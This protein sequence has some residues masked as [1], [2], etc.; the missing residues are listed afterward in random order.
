M[1]SSLSV[2]T[3]TIAIN[4]LMLDCCELH[5][6]LPSYSTRKGIWTIS[7]LSKRTCGKSFSATIR[8]EKIPSS[9]MNL[10]KNRFYLEKKTV[11]QCDLLVTSVQRLQQHSDQRHQQKMDFLL[12]QYLHTSHEQYDVLSTHSLQICIYTNGSARPQQFKHFDISGESDRVTSLFA[13]HVGPILKSDNTHVG[14]LKCHFWL[15]IQFDFLALNLYTL[16]NASVLHGFLRSTDNQCGKRL[17]SYTY[18]FRGKCLTVTPHKAKL[19]DGFL[20]NELIFILSIQS[21]DVPNL[22]AYASVGASFMR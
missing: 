21:R 9:S 13:I 7:E 5:E 18:H 15:L 10:L 12:K 1:L 22:V 16:V 11:F 4:T 17:K 6:S 19:S 2:R 20:M 14:Y 3:V 8:M